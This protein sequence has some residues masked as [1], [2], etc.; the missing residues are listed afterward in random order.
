[1][2]IS[3]NRK[4]ELI[5]ELRECADAWITGRALFCPGL[6]DE[7]RAFVM[8]SRQM[9]IL[10]DVCLKTRRLARASQPYGDVA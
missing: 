9:N 7:E 5:E 6:T 1:M 10:M 3:K 2:S 8:N 4:R